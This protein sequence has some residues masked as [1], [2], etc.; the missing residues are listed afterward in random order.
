M[1]RDFQLRS[2]ASFLFSNCHQ[3]SAFSCT[4]GA[5]N[6]RPVREDVA[7]FE[8]IATTMQHSFARQRTRDLDILEESKRL[9]RGL[10]STADAPYP[11]FLFRADHHRHFPRISSRH[12]RAPLAPGQQQQRPCRTF[13][14]L[15]RVQEWTS[16]RLP[17]AWRTSRD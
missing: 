5:I 6:I 13:P 17:L 14:A 1:S 12:W 16:K 8:L 11:V 4:R 15:E 2:R 9:F 3:T 7:T 10:A